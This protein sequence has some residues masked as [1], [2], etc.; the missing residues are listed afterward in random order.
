MLSEL[1]DRFVVSKPEAGLLVSTTFVPL[2]FAPLSYGIVL[3]QI[4]AC[5]L[6]VGLTSAG[7]R[8]G[9]VWFRSN[10]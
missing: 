1:A 7:G 5:N 8:Y 3:K 6:I 9:M 2:A 10:L 4:D